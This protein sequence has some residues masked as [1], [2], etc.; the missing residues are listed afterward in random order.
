LILFI[1]D[2]EKKAG[3]D[4]LFV[5]RIPHSALHADP[6]LKL[7]SSHI[8]C[9]RPE[10]YPRTPRNNDSAWALFR[11][12]DRSFTVEPVLLLSQRK[13]SGLHPFAE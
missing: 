1:A 6:D 3:E 12:R 11:G 5:Y 9:M 2:R 7:V 4:R 8:P 10:R 13:P